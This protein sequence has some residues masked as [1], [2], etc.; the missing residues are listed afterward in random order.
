V[1]NE[2][3]LIIFSAQNSEETTSDA[4]KCIKLTCKITSH[5]TLWFQSR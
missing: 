5:C 3:I 4:H 2:P 1:K